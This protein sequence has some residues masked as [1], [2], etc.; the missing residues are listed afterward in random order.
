[1]VTPHSS[2]DVRPHVLQR[3]RRPPAAARR[4][5]IRAP[6][7]VGV[8]FTATSF[9]HIPTSESR[10]TRVRRSIEYG[11]MAPPR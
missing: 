3:L 1:M 5:Y 11:A 9:E 10:N 2:R 4:G 7:F 6:L 8:Y